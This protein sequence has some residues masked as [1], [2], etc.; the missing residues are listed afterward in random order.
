LFLSQRTAETNKEKRLK[1]RR[2]NDQPKSWSSSMEGTKDWHYSW[3]PGVLTDGT[4]AWLSS[5]RPKKQLTE[6]AADT[7]TPNHWTKVR[8]PSGW[9]RSSI[10]ETEGERDSIWTPAVSIN[11]TPENSQK[12]SHQSGAY[13]GLSESPGIY[14]AEV[15][16]VWPQ[17]ESEASEKREVWWG[18][19]ALSRSQGGGGTGLGT[20]RGGPRAWAITG[21]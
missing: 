7:Y 3:R 4:L 15:F 20:V 8:G 17:W 10:E 19:G 1:G 12:L 11:Q 2:S 9:I 6:T 21:V 16:L 14:V 18:P 13:S 5:E